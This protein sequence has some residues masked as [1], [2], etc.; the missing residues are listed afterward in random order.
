MKKRNSQLGDVLAGLAFL[1]ISYELTESATLTT[2]IAISQ[3]TPYLLFGL[4][5]D[6]VDRV[7]KKGSC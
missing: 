1:F 7:N 2:V 3:A 5:G 4:I 6:A